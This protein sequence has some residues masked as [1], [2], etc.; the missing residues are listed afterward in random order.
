MEWYNITGSIIKKEYLS[1]KNVEVI[2]KG[3]PINN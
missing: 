3:G 1:F 2:E